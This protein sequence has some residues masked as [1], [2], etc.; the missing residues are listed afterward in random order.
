MMRTYTIVSMLTVTLLVTRITSSQVDDA[1]CTP[2]EIS[3][4]YD[5]CG[6]SLMLGVPWVFLLKVCCDSIQR[7]KMKCICRTVTTLFLKNFDVN[8]L[9]KLSHACGDLL[10]P[11]SYCGI[12]KVPKVHQIQSRET[13][14]DT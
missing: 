5:Y 6:D 8:K 12:Y 2:T 1:S 11:G 10:V 13:Q 7:D 9:S 3:E 14:W 4:E